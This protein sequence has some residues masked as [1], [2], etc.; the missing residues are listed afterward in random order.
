MPRLSREDRAAAREIQGLLGTLVDGAPPILETVMPALRRYL[1]TQ[2]SWSYGVRLE[3]D[4]CELAFGFPHGLGTETP[5]LLP[6]VNRWMRASR[7]R[8]GLFDAARV[9]PEQ[10]NRAL[11]LPD[12]VTVLETRDAEGVA[13]VENPELMIQLFR[14][15]GV[16][17]DAECRVLVCDGSRLLA[18]VGGMQPEPVRPVQAR[19]LAALV[20]ALK[21][22]LLLEDHLAHAQLTAT[23]LPALMEQLPRAAFL[24]DGRGRVLLAN[25]AARAAHDADPQGT[26]AALRAAVAHPEDPAYQ[27]TPLAV[28]TGP[29]GHLVIARPPPRDPGPAVRAAAQRYGLTARETEVLAHLATGGSNRAIAL[30][31]GCAERTVEVHVAH[32]LDKV[33]APSRSALVARVWREGG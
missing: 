8:F 20:P 17:H 9:D 31:L 30:S 19:R 13:E 1:D 14:E 16:E 12:A 28:L 5:K 23:A 2:W 6:M 18:W 7:R 11:A 21:R 24:L 29:Q 3:P 33:G 25:A 32:L 10:R 27:V 26:A 15:V 22:R 4:G